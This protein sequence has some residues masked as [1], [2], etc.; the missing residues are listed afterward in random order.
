MS[1]IHPSAFLLIG[2]VLA[3]LPKGIFRHLA[4]IAAP[5]LALASAL[6]L[7]E[8]IEGVPRADWVSG[9][10]LSPAL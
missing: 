2:A 1:L 9:A 10:R 6:N 7:A 3:L 8:G 4:V 5:L